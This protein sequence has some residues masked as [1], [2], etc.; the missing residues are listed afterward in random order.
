MY[1]LDLSFNGAIK[2]GPNAPVTAK[3]GKPLPPDGGDPARA[4]LKYRKA[5]LEATNFEELQQIGKESRRASDKE[6]PRIQDDPRFDTPEKKKLMMQKMFELEK[7]FEAIDDLKITGG[8]VNSDRA[9][10]AFTGTRD[11]YEVSGRSNMHLENGQWKQGLTTT[12]MG[13]KLTRAKAPAAAATS[14]NTS[15]KA[16]TGAKPPVTGSK[17]GAGAKPAASVLEKRPPATQPTRGALATSNGTV[18][19]RFTVNGKLIPLK[20]VYARRRDAKLPDRGG[21]IDLF[22]T[23]QPVPEEVLAKI[24]ADK[25]HSFYLGEDYFKE[26]SISG[27]YIAIEKG[28]CCDD[29]VFYFMTVMSPDG[30]VGDSTEFTTFT[31]Q[32]GALKARA[33]SKHDGD[34]MKWN[35]ALNLTANLGKLPSQTSASAVA[36]ISSTTP[37]PPD[38]GKAA[39]TLKLKTNTYNLKYAYTWKER[40][41]FDEPDERVFVL[42][43]EAPVP[44]N[45]KI[46]EDKMEMG[47]LIGS[48][49]IRGIELIID[50]SGVALQSNFLLKNGTLSDSTQRTELKEFRIENG[51]VKGKA[52]YKGED[53][54]RTYS[55][56]FDAPLKN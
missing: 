35:Y 10:L 8:F 22:V 14:A 29:K 47:M 4:F 21:T 49:K 37:L 46:F 38:E 43:T 33:E 20:Y 3:N 40:I 50:S 19:G 27:V 17:R 1:E 7:A 39:G 31:M 45:R 26:T 41:F 9:T 15:G 34:G 6:E 28:R 53:G 51:R 23:N 32:G 25:Y 55:V 30:Y 18:V 56:S 5:I 13:N 44:Q 16:E 52:E 12:M 42:M 2:E 24:Y 11:G 36:S 48:D 54:I